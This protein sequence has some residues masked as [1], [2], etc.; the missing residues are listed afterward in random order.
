MNDEDERAFAEYVTARR[1]PLLKVAW[2][3]TGEWHLAED[4]LQTALAKTYVAWRRV[5]DPD[6]YVSRVLTTTYATWWRRRWRGE[7]PTEH[8]P[9]TAGPDTYRGVELRHEL[10]AA[11]RRLPR[12][13][14]AVLVLRFFEDFTEPETAAA[15]GCS[16]GTVKSHTAR[17]LARLRGS[18]M[19]ADFAPL[20]NGAPHDA[21]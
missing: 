3:L 8:L 21:R 9:E 7:H 20:A 6:A 14:R 16:V 5:E 1:R 19:L 2:L 4:L 15:L 18:A 12:K 17:A 10:L 11:L 13:Q